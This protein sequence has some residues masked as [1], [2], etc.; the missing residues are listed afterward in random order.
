MCKVILVI[1]PKTVNLFQEK[2]QL[3]KIIAMS[4]VNHYDA[5]SKPLQWFAK[6][7]VMVY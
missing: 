3:K 1:K 2:T 4:P 6:E 5:F 7:I